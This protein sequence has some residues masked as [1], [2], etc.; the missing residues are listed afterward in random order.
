MQLVTPEEFNEKYHKLA[1][2]F[3]RYGSPRCTLVKSKKDE[4]TWTDVIRLDQNNLLISQDVLAKYPNIEADIEA[5]RPY[6]LAYFKNAT[7][8]KPRTPQPPVP[9]A[10]KTHLVNAAKLQ[11]HCDKQDPCLSKKG[12]D[13]K[14]ESEVLNAVI[15]I[16]HGGNIEKILSDKLVVIAVFPNGCYKVSFDGRS[17]GFKR[18]ILRYL[19]DSLN[20]IW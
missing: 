10:I 11:A 19:N 14:R 16:S 13:F 4:C 3:N 6:F 12:H 5:S 2:V 17:T 8:A 9:K 15:E 18:L 7:A 1:I 20:C